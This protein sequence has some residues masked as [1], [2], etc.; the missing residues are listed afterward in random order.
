MGVFWTCNGAADAR[1]RSSCCGGCSRRNRSTRFGVTRSAARNRRQR[2]PA[3]PAGAPCSKSHSQTPTR[4]GSTSAVC[5]TSS[6]STLASRH[7]RAATEGLL[8]ATNSGKSACDPASL[9][10]PNGAKFL[11]NC[12]MGTADGGK[13]V[14]IAPLLPTSPPLTQTRRGIRA[15]GPHFGPTQRARSGRSI[16]KTTAR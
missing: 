9:V 1:S 7:A 14:V 16:T 12:F 4:S 15:P 6:G 3:A 10:D 11:G 2:V 5:A 13:A 8:R